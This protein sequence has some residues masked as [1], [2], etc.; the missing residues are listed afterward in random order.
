MASL[1]AGTDPILTK[2]LIGI[3][4]LA[5]VLAQPNTDLYLD[6]LL[7]GGGLFSD[8]GFI[9]VDAGEWWRTVTSGFLHA[10][11][12]HIG[13][14]MFLLWLLGSELE[15]ALGRLR[16]GLLYGTSLLAGSFGV[17]LL[18]P[19]QPTVGASGA[20]F[21]LMGAMIVAQR[22]SGINPWQSGIGGLVAINLVFTFAVPQIS[23]GG[24]LG[25]LLGGAL[26]AAVLVELPRRVRLGP[27]R[28]SETVTSLLAVA[29]GV[30]FYVGSLMLAGR[31]TDSFF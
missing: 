6:G 28:T 19:S 3:N 4:V 7:I 13:F 8:V 24:H 9:G 2:I 14:N 21:G 12:I 23:V 17:L 1:R 11:L 30:G 16:F 20:V 27:A 18:D 10:S 15:P 31:W 26:V 22:A 25:G 5:F 29:L